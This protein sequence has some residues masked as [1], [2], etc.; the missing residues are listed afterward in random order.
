[1]LYVGEDMYVDMECKANFADG[2]CAQEDVAFFVQTRAHHEVTDDIISV[3]REQI[4]K[5]THGCYDLSGLERRD[6]SSTYFVL[7]RQKYIRSEGGFTV[8]FIAH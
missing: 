2:A 1:M 5:H 7:V 4:W 8:R 3:A 6:Q